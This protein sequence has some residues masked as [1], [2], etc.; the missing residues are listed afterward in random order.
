M[1]KIIKLRGKGRPKKTHPFII[2]GNYAVIYDKSGR[3]VLKRF[4]V[5]KKETNGKIVLELTDFNKL[6]KRREEIIKNLSNKLGDKI[7]GK[8]LIRDILND[9]DYEKLEKLN[10]AIERGAE[11][12]PKEGCFYLQIKDKKSKKPLRLNVRT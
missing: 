3:H 2:D 7:D 10:S 9:T 5:S 8:M 11:V 1:G 12:K 4:R 6:N